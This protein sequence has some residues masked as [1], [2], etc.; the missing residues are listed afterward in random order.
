MDLSLT[1]TDDKSWSVLT[2]SG[3]FDT[4]TAS[5]VRDKVA[6]VVGQA[7]A[8]H[9]LI[10][11]REVTFMDSSALGVLVGALR[12]ARSLGGEVRIIGPNDKLVPL[13][14]I[15]G[16][17]RTFATFET[18]EAAAAAPLEQLEADPG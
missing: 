12:T 3:E 8:P 6:E 13:F 1:T 5:D 2:L 17:N 14:K 16:L 7:D 10:D 9:I 4:L 18:I 15:T 11:L